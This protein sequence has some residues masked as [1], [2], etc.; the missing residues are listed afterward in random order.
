MVEDED[1]VTVTVQEADT[2]S[3]ADEPAACIEIAQ[4]KAAAADLANPL[5]GRTLIDG[6]TGEA[7]SLA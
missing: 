1:T 7:L 4:A 5:A 6:A 3:T 2:A